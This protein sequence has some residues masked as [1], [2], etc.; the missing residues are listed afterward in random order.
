MRKT[1][2]VSPSDKKAKRIES[3]S[4]THSENDLWKDLTYGTQ[5]KFCTVEPHHNAL[6][7]AST[8]FLKRYEEIFGHD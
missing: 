5:K 6:Q 4:F 8:M 2:K 1:C 7:P 3:P